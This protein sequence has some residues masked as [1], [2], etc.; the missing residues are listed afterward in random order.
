VGKIEVG[1]KDK[2]L[3]VFMKRLYNMLVQS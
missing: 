3:K 1:G 2:V